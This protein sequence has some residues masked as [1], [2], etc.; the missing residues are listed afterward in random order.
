MADAKTN[1]GKKEEENQRKVNWG[2]L[3]LQVASTA[4]T[5]FLTGFSLAAGQRGFER[6]FARRMGPGNISD[7]EN[8]IKMSKHG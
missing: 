6:V 7:M 3:A 5:G 2:E 8:V 1:N 4:A